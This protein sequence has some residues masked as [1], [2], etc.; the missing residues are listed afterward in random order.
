MSREGGRTPAG[1]TRRS[2]RVPVLAGAGLLLA[3]ASA[4]AQGKF[5]PDSLKNVLALP[6]GTTVE[7]KPRP[8]LVERLAGL[9]RKAAHPGSPEEPKP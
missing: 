8:D 9:C 6:A 1:E 5:P 7:L 3:A 2:L 4:P